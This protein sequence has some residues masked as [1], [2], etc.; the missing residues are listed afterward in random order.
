MKGR[1]G[2]YSSLIPLRLILI[3]VWAKFDDFGVFDPSVNELGA[4]AYFSSMVTYF[5]CSALLNFVSLG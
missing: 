4:A 5:G 3:G 1:A 2:D